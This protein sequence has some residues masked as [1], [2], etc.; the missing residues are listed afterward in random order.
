[1]IASLRS[2]PLLS[3]SF[4]QKKS[5]LL[6]AK[7]EANVKMSFTMQLRQN[8]HP[9][10]RYKEEEIPDLPSSL[11]PPKFTHRQIP[12]NPDLPE[13]CFPTVSPGEY[14]SLV[15]TEN[16]ES[17][18]RNDTAAASLGLQISQHASSSDPNGDVVFTD[19]E[20]PA[21]I[22]EVGYSGYL[23]SVFL[24]QDSLDDPDTETSQDGLDNPNIETSQ[25]S[26]D[27]PETEIS[28][29][30][31]DDADAEA[32]SIYER[33]RSFIALQPEP[34][35][36][37]DDV[38]DNVKLTIIRELT[39]SISFELAVKYLNLEEQEVAEL[40]KLNEREMRLSREEDERIEAL[41][42]KHLQ[43]LMRGDLTEK[44]Y[45]YADMMEELNDLEEHTTI[46]ITH[47]EIKLGASFLGNAMN[48]IEEDEQRRR[49]QFRPDRGGA[50]SSPVILI[51][52]L[53]S[54]LWTYLGAETCRNSYPLCPKK[55]TT[56]AIQGHSETAEK[57]ASPPSSRHP[58]REVQGSISVS[59]PL[60]NET[61]IKPPQSP[62]S[63]D[64]VQEL[65]R[66]SL[67]ETLVTKP[68]ALTTDS[69]P[70]TTSA[71]TS[72]ELTSPIKQERK[73]IRLILPNKA[74]ESSS[75]G[76]PLRR[77]RGRPRKTPVGPSRLRN[78]F[79]A[80]D[81]ETSSD[82]PTMS[83]TGTGNGSPAKRGPKPKVTRLPQVSPSVDQSTSGC[84]SVEPA[85]L[86]LTTGPGS[87]QLP[88]L[89]GG[90]PAKRLASSTLG[91]RRARGLS[92]QTSQP[93]QRS[94]ANMT[95]FVTA[96]STA[97]SP[98]QSL[99]G[100]S[101]HRH[102]RNH[103]IN[104]Q[105]TVPLDSSPVQ[106][107]PLQL[108]PPNT[109]SGRAQLPPL[110]SIE[111]RAPNTSNGRSTSSGDPNPGTSVRIAKS[112]ADKA[113]QQQHLTQN[114]I[115]VDDSSIKHTQKPLAVA[116]NYEEFWSDQRNLISSSFKDQ[117]SLV[118]PTPSVASQRRCARLEIAA[119]GE[120]SEQQ[121]PNLQANVNPLVAQHNTVQIPENGTENISAPVT[122]SLHREQINLEALK[123]GLQPYMEPA[124][125]PM[126]VVSQ[127]PQSA[128]NDKQQTSSPRFYRSQPQAKDS[129]TLNNENPASQNYLN[130]EQGI[131][132][133]DAHIAYLEDVKS[134]LEICKGAK[135][136]RPM[137]T[138]I[139]PAT[140]NPALLPQR[141]VYGQCFDKRGCYYLGTNIADPDDPNYL[142]RKSLDKGY[143][144]PYY[145]VI[146][147]LPPNVPT[148]PG[149]KLILP[150][151]VEKHSWW[152]NTSENSGVPIPQD[153]CVPVNDGGAMQQN[154]PTPE[155]TQ[156]LA[157][158]PIRN[159]SIN[160]A[161]GPPPKRRKTSAIRRIN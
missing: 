132:R 5:A 3:T 24:S 41:N 70:A 135:I 117:S 26:L 153:Q 99:P 125:P 34:L 152:L 109:N 29:D 118:P 149:G 55:W 104:Q 97:A 79:T 63:K 143:H 107:P 6:T 128:P 12:Y 136:L 91:T 53:V 137:Y 129:D 44:T 121:D 54:R 75:D 8:L 98:P 19:N 72:R 86:D 11:R 22:L 39:Q 48:L 57:T 82:Q 40:L 101:N 139:G 85:S 58:K 30:N 20:D 103:N 4:R 16:T 69:T 37:W 154:Q 94:P 1:M 115:S 133:P 102:A 83:S 155:N 96:G 59:H 76:P 9:P 35:A 56:A 2:P 131:A 31:L 112:L 124:V 116:R 71:T 45:E 62:D 141:L 14:R 25:D 142:G 78:S 10:G 64:D 18:Q 147:L 68:S 32:L 123:L 52:G 46:L 47:D 120:I 50:S 7:E 65:A 23:S 151:S 145:S 157:N 90:P 92:Q 122:Q 60:D 51:A 130:Q 126:R 61:P 160:N 87:S 66:Q 38:S 49:H 144:S 108:S 73:R 27:N 77:P 80:D 74:T 127:S 146:C 93:D 95:S 43:L 158:Q 113:Q 42:K 110:S 88:P 111:R 105:P 150:Q 36:S 106:L 134:R 138:E 17:Q 13:A 159:S 119:S 67:R 156:T 161:D 33:A 89:T 140:G 114:P 81:L 15:A 148:P 84:R 21:S 100:M 28:Q